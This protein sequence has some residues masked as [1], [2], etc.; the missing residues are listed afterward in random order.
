MAEEARAPERSLPR[1]I[2]ASLGLSTLLYAAVTV[3]AV[4]AAPPEELAAS[5]APLLL[6]ARDAPWFSSTAFAAVAL[7]AVANGVLLELV[8]LARL[9][10][11]M[12][13]R[14]WLPQALET[15]HP[16][17]GTP[18]RATLCGAAI[19]FLLTVALP[20]A[21]LVAVTSTITL[22]VFAAV[23]VA[24]WQLHRRAPRLAGFRAPRLLPPT[25]A[26]ASIALAAAQVFS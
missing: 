24:L 18:V 1:A 10:Y 22:L 12:A 13:R 5:P 2:L 3:V 23:N 14:G 26:V 15:V 16:R 20:F 17:L 9:L 21:S 8:M 25:A 19:V 7:V 6:V 4:L 11:G